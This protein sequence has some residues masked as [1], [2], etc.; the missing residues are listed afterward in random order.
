MDKIKLLSGLLITLS[1]IISG[2]TGASTVPE[3]KE[4]KA[5][6]NDYLDNVT[7]M[8]RMIQDL[9]GDSKPGDNIT[10][11]EYGMWLDGYRQKITACDLQY[12]NLTGAGTKYASYFNNQSDG[13]REIN[14]TCSELGSGLQK[15]KEN[16]AILDKVYDVNVKKSAALDKFKIDF[17]AA[18]G[19]S[20]EI[21]DYI[22]SSKPSSMDEYLSFING[23]RKKVDTFE[24]YSNDAITSGNEC[25]QYLDPQS[26]EYRRIS[27]YEQTFRNTLKQ[28]RDGCAGYERDYN[29]KKARIDAYNDYTAKIDSAGKAMK[30]VEDYR[31]SGT[32]LSR[33]NQSWINGYGQKVDTLA[34]RCNDAI[35]SGKRYQQYLD[36][37]GS[38]YAGISKNEKEMTDALAKHRSD[39]DGMKS[40]SFTMPSIGFKKS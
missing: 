28:Y 24:R 34:A 29:N 18:L 10:L 7:T 3:S 25:L 15:Q 30:D 37:E 20:N 38:E 39:Y 4:M 26:E 27:G 6:H 36:P 9:D 5:A 16:L 13:Y 31:S 14:Q 40:S 21:N 11:E 8:K 12:D 2:C 1:I 33:R 32:I 22:K 23:Y 35:A 19:L 17:D